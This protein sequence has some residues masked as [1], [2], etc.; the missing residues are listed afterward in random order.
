M[1]DTNFLEKYLNVLLWWDQDDVVL[2]NIIQSEQFV[3]TWIG[4][5]SVVYGEIF[6]SLKPIIKQKEIKTQAAQEKLELLTQR[7]RFLESKN[8]K[9]FNI[10]KETSQTF[11]EIKY[12]Y[13]K[14]GG[15]KSDLMKHNHDIW[16]IAS[17]LENDCILYTYDKMI[18]R[19]SEYYNNNSKKYWKLE[20]FP[21]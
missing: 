21:C 18:Q 19:I 10:T 20:F 14:L 9:F 5:N 4:I 17:C 6:Y 3:S 13:K 15:P 2:K 8:I 16:I 11:A 7:M 1:F 12:I